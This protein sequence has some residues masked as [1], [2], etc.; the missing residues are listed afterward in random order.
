MSF[1]PAVEPGETGVGQRATFRMAG[2]PERTLHLQVPGRHNALNAAAVVLAA[3][4]AGMA[5]EAAVRGVEAFRGTARRFEFRGAARGVRVFDDYAHHPTEVAAAVSAGRAV[6]GDARVHVLFQPHLF[7]RTRDF[8]AE[9]AAALSGADAVR[10]LPV[11]AAREESMPGV[12]SSLIASRLTT[13]AAE[14]RVVAEDRAEAVRSL[15]AG[16][17]AGDVVLTMGAGDVTALGPDLLAEL[18]RD[19]AP[20]VAHP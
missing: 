18:G 10:V 9:F 7:S 11:Y 2:G 6:A 16:A 19:A 3:V 20:G 1:H 15:A 12:D 13:G 8:A 17:T 5:F 14:D 4:R